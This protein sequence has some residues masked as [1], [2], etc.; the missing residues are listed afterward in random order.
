M[1]ELQT[2]LERLARKIR[3]YEDVLLPCEQQLT[4]KQA[5]H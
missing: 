4:N 2:T 5:E 1:D 3:H